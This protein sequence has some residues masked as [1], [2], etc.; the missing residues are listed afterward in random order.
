MRGE[1]VGVVTAKL[2]AAKVFQWT[3]DLPE[4]VNY[5]VKIAYLK[6][7]LSS[8]EPKAN[9][10][11]LSVEEASLEDLAA[12]VQNS[13]MQDVAEIKRAFGSG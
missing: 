12:R 6:G 13:V 9:L 10:Q 1:V 4:N 2:D 7:I 5:A 11:S 8:A 3:G